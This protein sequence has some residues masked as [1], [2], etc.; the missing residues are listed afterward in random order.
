MF[1]PYDRCDLK[2]KE[3]LEEEEEEAE[4]EIPRTPGRDIF[5]SSSFLSIFSDSDE[6]S[7]D[8]DGGEKIRTSGYWAISFRNFL[9]IY[10]SS[11]GKCF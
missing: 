6:W 2:E 11:T 7:S 9:F 3:E 4:W 8:K 5:P 1:F 10:S